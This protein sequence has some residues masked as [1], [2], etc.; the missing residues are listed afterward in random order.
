MGSQ[1]S[2]SFISY[3][4]PL[5]ANAEPLKIFQMLFSPY[6]LYYVP[7]VVAGVGFRQSCD[8]VVISHLVFA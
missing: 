7:M 3:V 1:T 2:P 4:W 6:E 8:A 5:R